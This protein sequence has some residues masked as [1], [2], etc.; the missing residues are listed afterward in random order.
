MSKFTSTTVQGPKGRWNCTV[1]DAKGYVDAVFYGWSK[2]EC[3]AK[4]DRHIGIEH[5][6]LSK[7]K[8]TIEQLNIALAGTT[9]IR[10]KAIQ[11]LHNALLEAQNFREHDP[12]SVMNVRNII[13]AALKEV[14]PA[15]SPEDGEPEKAPEPPPEAEG[16]D[17]TPIEEIV[18]SRLAQLLKAAHVHI[19]QDVIDLAEKAEAADQPREHGLMAI[20]GIGDNLAIEILEALDNHR[21]LNDDPE[22]ETPQDEVP[23]IESTTNTVQ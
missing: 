3:D 5:G 1:N 12:R 18:S 10:D 19:V 17:V 6:D 23:K 8:E 4:A 2:A 11:A 9:S 15:P 20:R 21:G 22:A 16:R 13:R 7:A 14:E